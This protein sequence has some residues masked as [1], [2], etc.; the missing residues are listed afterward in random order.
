[1]FDGF[2]ECREAGEAYYVANMTEIICQA[3]R[4]HAAMPFVK[5]YYALKCLPDATII[6]LLA[7]LD[8]GFDCASP[9]EFELLRD[10][11]LDMDAIA[12]QTVYANPCKS[13]AHLRKVDNAFGAKL[14]T[15]DCES[16][17]RKIAKTVPNARVLLRLKVDDAGSLCPFSAKFGADIDEAVSILHVCHEIGL[18]VGGVCFHVGS[19][20]HCPKQYD[21]ALKNCRTI[22]DAVAEDPV[23]RESPQF[24]NFSVVDIGGGFPG[25]ERH[26]NVRSSVDTGLADAA[27][28]AVLFPE[29]AD[30]VVE[31]FEKYFSDFD[32]LGAH[33]VGHLQGEDA[34]GDDL[35]LGYEAPAWRGASGKRPLAVFAEPGRY[36]VSKS[37]TLVCDIIAKKKRSTGDISVFKYY[38][39]EG[40]YQ[41][42][43]CMHFDHAQPLLL[44]EDDTVAERGT[45]T[46]ASIL[47]GPTCD[48]MDTIA[49]ESGKLR[50]PEMEIGD[51]LIV[52]AF[53]AYTAAAASTFNGFAKS[54]IF[55][56]L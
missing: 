22:F 39:N 27:D 37:H 17:A 3:K 8:C 51:R 45:S 43:N 24:R 23:L 14:M 30:C 4:W 55:Y 48:S 6:A 1:M 10:A 7:A 44:T 49:Y 15:F 50:M 13:P 25:V 33:G 38:L 54:K 21:A 29:I 12:R 35:L 41:S 56:V 11:G 40:V 34:K 28:T 5:P 2:A 46:Y 53:G 47:F 36:F 32:Y 16:E 42:F 19:N 52:P 18:S 26:D 20:C 31:S 9:A